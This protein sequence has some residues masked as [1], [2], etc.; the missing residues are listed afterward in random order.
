LKPLAA[1]AL[2]AVLAAAGTL[3][4]AYGGGWDVAAVDPEPGF[5]EGA[6]SAV[7]E[8]S[9]ARHAAGIRV[10]PLGDPAMLR[11]GAA[12]YGALCAACHGGPGVRPTEIGMGLNP[13]PPD[14]V[15]AAKAMP[16]REVYWVVK[17]GIR[18]TGMPAFGPAHDEREL[19][20]IVAFVERLPRMSPEAY[21]EEVRRSDRLL[22]P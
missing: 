20:S 15:D 6:L 10:P 22:S 19:W 9:V 8:R 2:L 17:H 13:G 3:V 14:L 16:A 1:L 12:R 11:L 4:Y 18:M 5:V 21:Q 7:S